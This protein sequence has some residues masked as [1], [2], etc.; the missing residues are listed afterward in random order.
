MNALARGAGGT[1]EHTSNHL[2]RQIEVVVESQC[3]Q[4]V[5]GQPV[6]GRIQIDAVSPA[7]FRGRGRRTRFDLIRADHLPPP[8]AA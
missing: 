6:E 3:Q 1:S 8:R 5:L 7:S 2:D 4:V